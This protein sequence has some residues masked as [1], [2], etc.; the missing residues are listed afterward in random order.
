MVPGS[1]SLAVLGKDAN[2]LGDLVMSGA[3]VTDVQ[4]CGSLVIKKPRF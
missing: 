3:K 1:E 2:E 4:S